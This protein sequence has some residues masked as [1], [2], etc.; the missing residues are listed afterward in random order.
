M[1]P[2]RVA[3][4]D[5]KTAIASLHREERQA[6]SQ[7]ERGE[8]DVRKAETPSTATGQTRVQTQPTDRRCKANHSAAASTGSAGGK[9]KCPRART[10]A[11]CEFHSDSGNACAVARQTTGRVTGTGDRDQPAIDTGAVVKGACG[12]LTLTRCRASR[13]RPLRNPCRRGHSAP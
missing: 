10:R 13:G 8:M 9:T 7:G 2:G 4:R 1:R 12:I 3:V 6:L 11:G 5:R